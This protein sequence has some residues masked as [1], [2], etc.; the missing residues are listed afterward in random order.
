MTLPSDYLEYPRRRYD[1]D[2]D[3]YRW[4][5]HF[6]IPAQPWPN[7]ARVALW[8]STSLEFFPLNPTGKP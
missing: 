2:N 5:P 7:G 1:M 3:W 8:L 4:R 6:A